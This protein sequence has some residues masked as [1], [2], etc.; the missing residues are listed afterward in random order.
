MNEANA[1]PAVVSGQAAV[2]RKSAA[3]QAQPA[4]VNM[5][6]EVKRAA[7]GKTE[8]YEIVGTPLKEES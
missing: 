3:V 1:Q 2:I 7:T 4:V 8:V 5:T 6:I